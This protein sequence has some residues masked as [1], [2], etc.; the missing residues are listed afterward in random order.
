MLIV[1][2]SFFFIDSDED[3]STKID[4]PAESDQALYGAPHSQTSA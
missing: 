1:S 4:A 3:F 2:V